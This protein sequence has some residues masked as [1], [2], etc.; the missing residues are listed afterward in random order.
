MSL[1]VALTSVQAPDP[2]P[3]AEWQDRQDYCNTVYGALEEIAPSQGFSVAEQSISHHV[4]DIFAFGEIGFA[5]ESKSSWVTWHYLP[6]AVVALVSEVLP[7]A[8]IRMLEVSEYT[9]KGGSDDGLSP[10]QCA[11]RLLSFMKQLADDAPSNNDFTKLVRTWSNPA[12]RRPIEALSL[13]ADGK[14][15][16][17]EALCRSILIGDTTYSSIFRVL[18]TT[19]GIIERNSKIG[20][21]WSGGPAQPPED[22]VTFIHV[23]YDWIHKTHH[24]NSR[25]ALA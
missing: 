20:V 19:G 8:S 9:G 10:E 3:I 4:G 6:N 2:I 18:P 13:I 17:A 12:L 5:K 22:A 16:E 14:V 24:T 1:A 7:M 21:Y 23:I 15:D 11:A 25:G